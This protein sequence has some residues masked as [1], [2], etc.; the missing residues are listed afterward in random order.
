M[1]NLIGAFYQPICTFINPQILSTLPEDEMRCGMA[2]IVKYG[3]IRDPELFK[4]L[5]T[6]AQE[7]RSYNYLDAPEKWDYIIDRSAQNKAD[8]VQLDEKKP[9]FEKP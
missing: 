6:H 7:L 5:E 9:G 2:E 3:I 1:E 4:Y 8:V